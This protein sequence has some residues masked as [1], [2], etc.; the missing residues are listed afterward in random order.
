MRNERAWPQQCWKNCANGSIIVALRFGDHGT[1]N[2]GICW[3]KFL[4]GFKLCATTSN[5]MQQG[6]QTDTTCNIPQFWELLANNVASVCTGL[7][8]TLVIKLFQ[9]INAPLVQQVSV[10]QRFLILSFFPRSDTRNS[11]STEDLIQTFI[12]SSSSTALTSK[13][14]N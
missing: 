12:I 13:S 4:T 1:E 9:T 3:L 8:S 6:V 7:N 5:N 14:L 11:Y 10:N 2:V